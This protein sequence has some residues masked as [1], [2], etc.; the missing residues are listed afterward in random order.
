MVEFNTRGSVLNGLYEYLEKTAD[1]DQLARALE[2]LPAELRAELGKCKHV[3]WYPAAY[4]S[5]LNNAIAALGSN[6]REVYDHVVG[7]G[8]QIA[9]NALNS[10]MRLMLR[11]L[12]PS[13]FAGKLPDL[14]RRDNA[15]GSFEIVELY[16]HSAKARMEGA[17]VDHISIAAIGYVKTALQ[18]ITGTDVRVKCH[19]WSVETPRPEV[20]TYDIDWSGV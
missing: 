19:G 16:K 4:F 5:D 2:T 17:P 1:P 12:T 8:T 7:G 14:W 9:T 10:F 6:E 15:F 13:M 18:A 3:G 11:M 20:A